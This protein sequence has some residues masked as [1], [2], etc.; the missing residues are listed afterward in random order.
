[1]KRHRI[2]VLGAACAIYAASLGACSLFNDTNGLS[3]T[4]T[5]DG[6]I[7]DQ[8]ATDVA[9][10]ESG[11]GSDTGVNPSDA[12]SALDA[13]SDGGIDDAAVQH[14]CGAFTYPAVSS[15]KDDFTTGFG[16]SW[17]TYGSTCI[18][19]SNGDLLAQPT[20]DAS[21]DFCH[22]WTAAF[23]HL[24]CDSL[25]FKVAEATDDVLG[26]Q[27]FVYIDTP[28]GMLMLIKE[29]AG[30][31][32][33]APD[34]SGVAPL[35][36]GPYNAA[37]DVWWRLRETD[38][39]LYFETSADGVTW[40]MRGS[41]PDPVSLDKVRIAIGAGVYKPVAMPGQA[42]FRCYNLLGSCQ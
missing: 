10:V 14:D 33:G 9:T 18:S 20:P 28:S 32:L 5:T 2:A 37:Q 31:Q 24:T 19:E 25:T 23:Y 30:F 27:T 36:L 8:A 16:A 29:S 13:R 26:A 1:M 15:F 42:R 38:G 41:E 21:N 22:V 4:P 35:S 7:A 34:D 40:N 3:S 12:P 6:A 17:N 39:R 11:G